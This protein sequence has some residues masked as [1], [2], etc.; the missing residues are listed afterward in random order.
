LPD[1]IPN[2]WTLLL[3]GTA[4]WAL[5][6]YLPLSG[7]LSRLEEA[8]AAGPLA[9]DTQQLLLV[10]SSLLLALAVGALTNLALGWALGPGWGTS[11]GLMAAL[12]GLFWGL[13]ANRQG[14]DG[15]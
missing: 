11:L 6:F 12:Y 13:A 9:E 3:P 10:G 8:L 7:P 4:L 15:D 5:A 2:S 14:A 1:W